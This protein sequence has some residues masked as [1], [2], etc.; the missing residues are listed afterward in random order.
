MPDALIHRGGRFILSLIL[1]ACTLAGAEARA[2]RPLAAVLDFEGESAGLNHDEIVSL[3]EDARKVALEVLQDGY[4]IITRENLVD[5]LK[6][7][8]RTLEQCEG[9]CETETGRL[10]GAELVVTGR[11]A[12][13][14]K[15]YKLT[16]KIHQTDPPK[17]M[18]IQDATTTAM[19]ELPDLLVNATRKLLTEAV[20]SPGGARVGRKRAPKGAK[21][22]IFIRCDQ[23]GTRY[24][25]EGNSKL[26]G[27]FKKGKEVE[28]KV[29]YR[30]RPY[31]VTLSKKGFY[32]RTAELVVR[33]GGAPPAID[34]TLEK[35]I[36]RKSTGKRAM[37]SIETEP[38]GA[39]VTIDGERQAAKTPADYETTQGQHSIRIERKNYREWS[40]EVNIEKSLHRLKQKLAANFASVTV[41]AQPKG[42][43]VLLN[44]RPMG[45][46]CKRGRCTAGGYLLT[47]RAP[48][49]HDHEESLVVVAGRD[50]TKKI[51]LKPAFGAIEVDVRT[52]IHDGKP[53]RARL[54]LDDEPSNVSMERAANGNGYRFTGRIERVESGK[55][56]VE[57]QLDRF[58]RV[59]KN[60][61]VRDGETVQVK[62]DAQARFGVVDVRSTPRGSQVTA[63]GEALGTTPGRFILGLGNHELRLTTNSGYHRPVTKQVFIDREKPADLQVTF[64]EITGKLVVGSQPAGAEILVDGRSYGRAPIEAEVHIG[65]RRVEARKSGFTPT[66]ER[67]TL[68]EGDE[69]FVTM[70]LRTLGSIAVACEA[71]VGE[72]AAV[73]IQLD[74][75]VPIRALS[76][77]FTELPTGEHKVTCFS[78]RGHSVAERR[79]VVPGER[80]DVSINLNAPWVLL[81]AWEKKRS[82]YRTGTVTLV[83]GAVAAA[84][85]GATKHVEASKEDAKLKEAH[86]RFLVAVEEVDLSLAKA[87]VLVAQT[88][89]N[90]AATLSYIGFG[91]AGASLIGALV[92]GWLSPERPNVGDQAW[93]PSGAPRFTFNLGPSETVHFGLGLQF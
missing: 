84:T 16:V 73:M 28:L 85:W 17:L 54:L 72:R 63:E 47:V 65:E 74:D 83:L 67:V 50:V 52:S 6:S 49:H 2:E 70:K 60:V 19:E 69:E 18:G 78:P 22:S 34:Y 42:A 75:K 14:F 51:Q 32:D 46:E 11:V 35:K 23:D 91:L 77:H 7:H 13:V 39:T 71:P 86:R 29:P 4:D 1:V 57:I 8:G 88:A 64:E 36:E 44:G 61:I 25:V 56:V 10:I 31:R 92:T 38:Q 93:R 66:L 26:N 79:S 41:R 81:A 90:D 82:N 30:D 9:E 45:D 12:R 76:H 89:R 62:A 48:L 68:T 87:D 27:T 33:Y 24:A 53:P 40:G 21:G 3:T 55:H 37:L 59:V 58:E 80:F 43:E 5:L 15:K 20:P